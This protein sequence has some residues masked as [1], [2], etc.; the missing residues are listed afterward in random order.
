MDE[1]QKYVEWKK[2]DTEEHIQYDSTYIII[3]SEQWLP[4]IWEGRLCNRLEPSRALE[5]VHLDWGVVVTWVY[6]FVK[7]LSKKPC[8]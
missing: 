4:C 8:T 6:I 1:S 7:T 5:M 2:P 3:K